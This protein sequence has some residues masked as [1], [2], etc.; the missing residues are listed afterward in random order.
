MVLDGL[1]PSRLSCRPSV[2]DTLAA[3]LLSQ[4][5]QGLLKMK[6]WK[7]NCRIIIH[8]MRHLQKAEGNMNEQARPQIKHSNEE[9][10]P[11]TP[12]EGARGVWGGGGAGGWWM[13][14]VRMLERKRSELSCIN[15]FPETD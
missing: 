11:A 12:D 9:P 10:G 3:V 15:Q 1:Q 7:R 2:N 6:A 14:G 13:G 8:G 5:V 4:E